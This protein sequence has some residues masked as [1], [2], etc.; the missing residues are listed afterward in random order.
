LTV[1]TA[2][3]NCVN[4]LSQRALRIGNSFKGGGTPDPSLDWPASGTCPTSVRNAVNPFNRC[5]FM[6]GEN[7]ETQNF[8]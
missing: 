2:N 7:R 8:A 4:N 3:F 5:A 1:S 6:E